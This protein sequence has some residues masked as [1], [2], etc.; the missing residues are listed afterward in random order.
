M[1]I[2][3]DSVEKLIQ[4]RILPYEGR[5][6]QIRN[7]LPFGDRVV[8]LLALVQNVDVFVWSP[9]EVLGIDPNFI[10]H[11][12]NMDLLYPP[13]RRKSRRSAK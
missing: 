1:D 13:K 3:A 10:I 5:Y 4:F 7:N 9:Y 8:V 12:L 11:K 6:F 2:R